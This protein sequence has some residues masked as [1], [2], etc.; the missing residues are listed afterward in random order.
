MKVLCSNCK[1]WVYDAETI[2]LPLTLKQL[3]TR[4]DAEWAPYEDEIGSWFPCPSCEFDIRDILGR[5]LTDVGFMPLD[6]EQTIIIEDPE[7]VLSDPD[8]L[9]DLNPGLIYSKRSGKP[10]GT[11][12]QAVYASSRRPGTFE[13]VEVD[14]GWALREFNG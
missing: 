3:Q 2:T 13:P 4:R 6:A 11:E 10:Y 14:G 9:G 12:G 5:V 1:E 8:K 7:G